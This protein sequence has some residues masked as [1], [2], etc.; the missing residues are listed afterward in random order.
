MSAI[1][2]AAAPRVFM[3]AGEASGDLHGAALARA[4]AQRWPGIELSGIGG[5]KMAAAGVRLIRPM[6]KISVVGVAEVLTRAPA[7]VRALREASRAIRAEKPHLFVPIDFPD[8]N[9]KLAGT[10]RKAGVP[11]LYYISPQVWAWRPGR[12]KAMARVVDRMMVIFPFE[13]PLYS[14]AGVP[15][16]YVGHPL[17]DHVAPSVD[18]EAFR[19]RHGLQTGRLTLALLPGSRP[20]EV[21]RLAGPMLDTVG[22]LRARGHD[23]DCLVS[24]AE[25]LPEGSVRRRVE[26]R[27]EPALVVRGETYDLVRASDFVLVASGTATLEVALLERPMVILYKVAA[28]SWAIAKRLVRIPQIGLANIAAGQ[29]VVPELLQSDVRAEKIGPIVEAY[30]LDPRLR[31]CV[32]R[33]LSHVRRR[34]GTGGASRRAAEVVVR[35]LLERSAAREATGAGPL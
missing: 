30:L 1:S 7:I 8:F 17:V 2:T 9:L 16:E 15:V 33:D 22:W 21:E 35:T 24:E 26:A 20:H 4:L 25:S 29:A 27:G 32:R 18:A 11:V 13:V 31:E 6:H 14:Q 10:A 12:V 23:L 5:P 19:A 3:V 28:L 34:L